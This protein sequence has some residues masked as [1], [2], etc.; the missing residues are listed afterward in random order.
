MRIGFIGV[1]KIA[2]AITEGLCTSGLTGLEIF[3]SPRSEATA[4]MLAAKFPGVKRLGSNQE[5]LDRASIVIVSVR[6]AAAAE[7]LS[8]L[9]FR[10]DHTV[11]SVVAL[12][13][14]ADL[15]ALAAPAGSV[16]RA[17]PLPTVVQH[18]CPIP[19]FRASGEVIR[20]FGHLGDPLVVQDEGQLHAI[21]TLTGLITPFYELLGQLA[22]WTIQHGVDPAIANVYTADL[23]QC[24]SYTAQ[25]SVPID[26][27]E[28]AGH[29]ATPNGM[30][31][32]AGLEIREA[33]AHRAWLAAADKLLLRFQ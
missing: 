10:E 31:E 27:G 21:W 24:L 18:N 9:R 4:T 7:V 22:N 3:L 29:A 1:G 8:A 28:L 30:N 13:K 23:F 33:G 26:Y 32:Q 2:S 19:L 16:C 15:L 11:I 17:I 20:L 14:Y 25:Q 12:L 5:V 6:P